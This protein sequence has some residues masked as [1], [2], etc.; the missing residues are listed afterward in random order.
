LSASASRD[1]AG[2]SALPSVRKISRIYGVSKAAAERAVRS[3]VRDGICYTQHGRG[4]F[5]AVENPEEAVSGSKTIGVVFGFL[6]YPRTDHRFYR[7]V[8]EGTQEWTARSRCN[9]LKLFSWR[10]K[11]AGQK[12]NELAR[13][14]PLLGGLVAL[15]IY[16]DEDC[17]LLRNT[18]LPLV[19]LDY[20]TE[21]LGIDC[22]VLNNYRTM[23][24]LGRRLMAED[25]GEVFLVSMERLSH[26][27]PALLERRTALERAMAEAD[28]RL[29]P[30]NIISMV[31]ND[32]PTDAEDRE[33]LTPVWQ[34]ARQGGRRTAVVSVD[35]Y[36]VSRICTTLL[37]LGLEPGRDFLLAY[38]GPEDMPDEL[39]PHPAF[40]GAYDYHELGRLGTGLLERRIKTGPG[41][42]VKAVV[43]GAV[44]EYVPAGRRSRS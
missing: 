18:G 21:L 15:G 9:V 1:C 16:S 36:L 26:D 13:F 6:E 42:P 44:R 29:R 28:R 24:E 33:R 41:R 35:E 30:G 3:L 25:P 34:A 4:V 19:V 38:V 37:D 5:L 20:D 11:S 22:A 17:I 12:A 14:A 2:G 40:I 8:Y 23:Y 43:T 27:A 39:L 32:G 31:P 7:Q 10:A